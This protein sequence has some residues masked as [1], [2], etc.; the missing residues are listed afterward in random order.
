MGE[1]LGT[2]I[3]GRSQVVSQQMLLIQLKQYYLTY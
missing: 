3:D 2:E 1:K